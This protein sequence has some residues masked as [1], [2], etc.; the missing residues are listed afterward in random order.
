[1]DEA[2]S[3]EVEALPIVDGW[4]DDEPGNS[5]VPVGITVAETTVS[6]PSPALDVA[7]PAVEIPLY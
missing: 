2:D 7:D 4:S 3:V 6:D 5:T 1:M